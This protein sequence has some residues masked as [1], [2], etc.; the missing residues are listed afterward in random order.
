VEVTLRLLVVKPLYG[1]S[2]EATARGGSDN[3]GVWQCCRLSAE[4]VSAAT[5]LLHWANLSQPA[6][7]HRLL[8]HGGG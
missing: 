5:T 2:Y 7:R 6:T 1:W 4:P 8:E 3:L